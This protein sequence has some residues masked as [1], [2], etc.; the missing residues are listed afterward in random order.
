[1]KTWKEAFVFFLPPNWKRF[2]FQRNIHGKKNRCQKLLFFLI[3]RGGGEGNETAETSKSK[4]NPIPLEKLT[5]SQ[6]KTD[7]RH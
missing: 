5:S 4:S 2:G 1:M 6:K 7:H 3:F